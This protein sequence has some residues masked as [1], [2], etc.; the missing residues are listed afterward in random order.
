M[1]PGLEGSWSV[2][3]SIEHKVHPYAIDIACWETGN[4][5]KYIGVHYYPW[6]GKRLCWHQSMID[7][8]CNILSYSDCHIISSWIQ[9]TV[10]W[11][12]GSRSLG[13]D[14]WTWVSTSGSLGMELWVWIFEFGALDLLG[15]DLWVWMSESGSLSL[16]LWISGSGSPRS[17]SLWLDLWVGTLDLW[18]WISWVRIFGF[19]TLDLL[20]LDSGSPRS[21]SL[22]L[23]FLVWNNLD[24]YIWI[25]GYGI[26]EPVNEPWIAVFVLLLFALPNEQNFEPIRVV[27]Q[28]WIIKTW[29][30]SYLGPTGNN[31]KI[32]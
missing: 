6:Y 9:P 7:S 8:V 16:E 19:G 4:N 26:S 29:I 1:T 31:L 15:L 17:G 30:T 3:V 12:S 24:L 20:G 27:I 14:L 5:I 28:I 10:L 13:L 11:I 18:V 25:S 22:A 2:A 32:G 23:D 21:V